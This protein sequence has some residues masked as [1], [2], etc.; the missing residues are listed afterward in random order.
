MR[1]LYLDKI[2]AYGFRQV[3]DIEGK[4]IE[5][6]ELVKPEK[7]EIISSFYETRNLDEII[8]LLDKRKTS[9]TWDVPDNIHNRVIE[10]LKNKY[11]RKRVEY[12]FSSFLL[13]WNVN[14]FNDN[15]LQEIDQCQHQNFMK[16][17]EPNHAYPDCECRT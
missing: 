16:S 5:L 2:R 6:A 12:H 15:I 1:H 9:I 3:Y 14:D 13:T 10:E 17:T 11:S 7:S 4:E 8:D